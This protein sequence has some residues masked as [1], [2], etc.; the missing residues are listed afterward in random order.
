MAKSAEPAEVLV[1]IR[2]AL[3][4][5]MRKGEVQEARWEWVDLA[6]GEI[7]IPKDFHKTGRKTGKVRIVHLCAALVADL[8]GLTKTLVPNVKAT[9]PS[10]TITPTHLRAAA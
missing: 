6:A 2:L 1:A 8:H 3:L 7:R 4:A 9:S 5:G 10:A